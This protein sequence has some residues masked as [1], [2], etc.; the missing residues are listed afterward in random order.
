MNQVIAA[1]QAE[2]IGQLRGAGWV[3]SGD[4]IERKL[5]PG[6]SKAIT[7]GH[8][9]VLRALTNGGYSIRNHLQRLSSAICCAVRTGEAGVI[10][11]INR[12]RPPPEYKTI[13]DT[14]LSAAI[15]EASYQGHDDVLRSLRGSGLK[16]PAEL[17][18][19]AIDVAMAKGSFHAAEVLDRGRL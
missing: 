7:A 19:E 14:G 16:M 1:G 15:L 8:E 11:V 12:A 5:L 6:V 13:L 10:E 18:R 2:V 3:F 9:E 17:R 4:S